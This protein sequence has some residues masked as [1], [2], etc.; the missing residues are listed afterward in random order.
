MQSLHLYIDCA[1]VIN[2]IDY[3]VWTIVLI[4]Y[5]GL[6]LVSVQWIFKRIYSCSEFS[7]VIVLSGL[8]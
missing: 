7:S 8:I 5:F 6:V 1:T 4:M 2:Y 3:V